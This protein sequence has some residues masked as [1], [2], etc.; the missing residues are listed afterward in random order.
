MSQAMKTAL[1]RIF[2][3]IL[4]AAAFCGCVPDMTS[5]QQESGLI[6]TARPAIEAFLD[7]R[8][9]AY[10][11]RELKMLPGFEEPGAWI[12]GDYDSHA[13][14]CDYSTDAGAF[15][16]AYDSESGAFYTNELYEALM[17]YETERL[18]AYLRGSGMDVALSDL[19]ITE[20]RLVYTVESHDIGTAYSGSRTFDTYADVEEMLPAEVTEAELPAFAESGFGGGTITLLTVHYDSETPDAL[21]D[22]TVRDFMASRTA[23]QVRGFL[24][25]INDHEAEEKNGTDTAAGSETEGTEISLPCSAL[26]ENPLCFRGKRSS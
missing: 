5:N 22:E 6:D 13:V 18:A 25:L 8:H 2:A 26:P 15:R 11:I 12:G 3:I 17:A 4:I 9:G 7:E 20:L 14:V 23:Y 16:L 21:T 19:R 1:K 24:Y 10:E